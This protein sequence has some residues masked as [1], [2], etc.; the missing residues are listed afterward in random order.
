MRT[1]TEQVVTSECVKTHL[2]PGADGSGGAG[3]DPLLDTVVVALAAV[4]DPV[5]LILNPPEEGVK[6]ADAELLVVGVL[7]AAAEVG[8]A[9]QLVL[10]GVGAHVA[11]AVGALG[12]D[13]AETDGKHGCEEGKKH[14]AT[15]LYYTVD[16]EG[17]DAERQEGQREK[18]GRKGQGKGSGVSLGKGLRGAQRAESGAIDNRVNTKRLYRVHACIT[19]LPDVQIVAYRDGGE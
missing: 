13:R 10:D 16:A 7:E 8:L 1:P 19:S 4:V 18:G 2:K 14:T 6:N 15:H 12:N 5:D 3:A 17:E 11:D 9:A